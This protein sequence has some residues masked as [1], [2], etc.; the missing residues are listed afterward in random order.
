MP[1]DRKLQSI[2]PTTGE[3]IKEFDLISNEELEQKIQKS[4]KAFDQMKKMSI[5]E[6]AHLMRRLGEVLDKN[7]E[8]YGRTVTME[9]GKTLS[10]AIYEAQVSAKFARW[11][12]ANAG[13][14][15]ADR[16]LET[17]DIAS[18]VKKVYEPFGVLYQIV[19]FNYPLWQCYRLL[20]AALMAGNSALIR[21]S[22]ATTLTG[23]HIE[24]SFKEAG[25]PDGTVQLLLIG[26]EQSAKVIA[27]DRV[28]GVTLTGSTAAGR[29]IAKQAAENLKK[30]VLE[31]GGCDPYIVCE[32]AQINK[33]LPE[34]V[35]GRISNCGQCCAAAKRFIVNEKIYDG[36]VQQF[37]DKMKNVTM[38]DPMRNDVQLGPMARSDLRET[39]HKQVQQSIKE[40][41]KLLC[42]GFI[43]EGQGNFYP[44]TV[45]AD[46]PRN[47]LAAREEIFGPVASILKARDDKEAIE[48]A[49][50]SVYGLGGGVF[51]A[52]VNK[53]ENIAR[54]LYTGMVFINRCAIFGPQFPFGGVKQ[55]GYGKEC[56]EE[57]LLEWTNIKSIIIA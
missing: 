48:I 18:Q 8:K 1:Q 5:E 37:V 24:E 47:C 11:Y 32:D 39:V 19:P 36:F 44:P 30:H 10:Q 49:N 14:I 50:D 2:N 54:Q 40:G 26:R 45:L 33:I 13:K 28:R 16:N 46:V 21:H 22:H 42:G 20:T 12:A 9:M 17:L 23:F 3:L 7:A 38:G 41:A 34:A 56:G 4:E 27:D 15:L 25:F 57:G 35:R 43:P 55:S 51:S 53:A 31:L 6:R 29:Q 52:D